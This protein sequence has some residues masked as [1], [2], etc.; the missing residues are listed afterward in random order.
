VLY[1]LK[2]SINV[3]SEPS[4]TSQVLSIAKAGKR[5]TVFRRRG[6]WVQVG[7]EGPIGWVHQSLLGAAPP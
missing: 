1:V 5:L 7:E 6:E 4:I 2:P 3:R